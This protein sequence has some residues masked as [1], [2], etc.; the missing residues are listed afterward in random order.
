M[1]TLFGRLSLARWFPLAHLHFDLKAPQAYAFGVLAINRSLFPVGLPYPRPTSQSDVLVE[2]F[3]F[4][5]PWGLVVF[6][7]FQALDY[8]LQWVAQ[9]A[10]LSL[11]AG[12]P[13][14]KGMSG[15]GYAVPTSWAL[16]RSSTLG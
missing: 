5:I 12:E 1:H 13:Q 2:G 4:P 14:A 9:P 16:E 6:V 15:G 11:S 7:E 8:R 3:Y 10:L